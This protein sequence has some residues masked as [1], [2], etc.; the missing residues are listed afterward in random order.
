REWTQ[1]E[2]FFIYGFSLVPMAFFDAISTNFYMFSDRYLVGGEL[3]RLRLRPLSS[4]F[5]LIMEGVNFEFIPDLALGLAVLVYAWRLV[6][7]APSWTILAQLF[8]CVFG[9]W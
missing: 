1:P 3:D 8:L 7:P 9:A 5:Q 4:L 6:G 2:V